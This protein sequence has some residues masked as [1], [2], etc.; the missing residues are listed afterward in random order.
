MDTEKTLRGKWVLI[1][2]DEQDILEL[3]TE[4]LDMCRIDT[5]ASFDEA[6]DLLEKNPYDATQTRTIH[7]CAGGMIL[8][9]RAFRGS[10]PIVASTRCIWPASS[11]ATRCAACRP[12]S[13][14][15][16]PAV[17]WKTTPW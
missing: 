8:R 1:V 2:D 14:R 12:I 11:P 13:H 4:L 15:P 16:V 5:A 17:S 3:L 6:K 10:L 9:W 7:A